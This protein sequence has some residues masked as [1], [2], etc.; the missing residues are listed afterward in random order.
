[1]LPLVPT[2]A[3]ALGLCFLLPHTVPRIS[4]DD[5][6]THEG[7][8]SFC[9]KPPQ[10]DTRDTC[11]PIRIESRLNFYWIRRR[12]TS[13]TQH[14]FTC[15]VCLFMIV[16]R[17]RL[18]NVRTMFDLRLCCTFADLDQNNFFP[19]IKASTLASHSQNEWNSSQ[20]LKIKHDLCLF[21][22]QSNLF[23]HNTTWS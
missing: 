6:R 18:F 7:A 20:D 8:L 1:M 17:S 2:R 14:S 11:W 10:D 21:T 19:G 15:T 16:S 12:Y 3:S 9:K 13:Y 23:V 5:L 22:L 4:N